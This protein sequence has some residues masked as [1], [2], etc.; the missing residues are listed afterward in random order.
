M[1][2]YSERASTCSEGVDR[3][4]CSKDLSQVR[5]VKMKIL[6]H[7]GKRGSRI[8]EPLLEAGYTVVE[9]PDRTAK[10]NKIAKLW[11]LI[12]VMVKEQPDLILVDSA[13]LMCLT[14]YVLSVL[15]RIPLVVRVRADI[16]SIYEE[17]KEYYTAL[18]RI[19]ELILSKV[20]QC[21]F[22]KSTRLFSV[23]NHLK[24]TMKEKGIKEEKIRIV[25]FSI[26]CE[27]FH[28]L[29]K[30]D[31]LVRIMSAA[32]FTFK[33]KTA[34][35]LEILPVVDEVI[36]EHG[37]IHY[38][39]AGRGKFSKEVEKTLETLGNDNIVYL[40]YVKNVE[41]L[42][43]ETDIFVHYSYLDAYPAA[44]LEAL[45]SGTP[46]IANRCGGMV[47]QVQHGETGFLVDD[48]VTFKKALTQLITDKE[49]RKSMGQKG[50]SFIEKEFTL[51][52]V[53]ECYKNEIN[54][55]FNQ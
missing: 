52:A 30:E 10:T 45:S 26:D 16:W 7:T 43:A 44:V 54:D 1:H 35:L 42:F 12:T 50:R 8:E 3:L 22:K 33:R 21:V 5:E 2:V 24:E 40:G 32:N 46:V 31:D 9:I 39:I 15:F 27:R 14:A 55:I 17:Q 20:C 51:S 18:Q 4:F 11:K 6:I 36:S 34:G 41:S 19:Y 37:N 25:R 53:A 38:F 49:M 29:K 13:G 23:S 28:P 47:E 48:A